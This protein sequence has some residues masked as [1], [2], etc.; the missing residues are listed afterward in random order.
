[1][2]PATTVTPTEAGGTVI[3]APHVLL[4]DLLVAD[5]WVHVRDG[6]VVGA[7]TGRP[8]AATTV[9]LPSGTLAPG[10]VDGQ[11]NGAFGHDLVAADGAGWRE[12]RTRL[13][14]TGVTAFVPTFITAPVDELA[15]ALQR[16]VALRADARRHGGARGLG[17]HLEGPFLAAGRHGAH[18]V[19][20]LT[21]PTDEAIDRLLAA[22][23]GGLAYVTLAPERPG[24]MAAIARFTA[25]GVRVA[26]G[27][28]DATDAQVTAA[29][30]AGATLVTH[31]YNAQRGLGHRD[32]GVVGAALTDPRLTVGLIVDLHH[33][34]PTAIRVA[35][36]AAGGRVMLVTDAVAAMGM[37]AGTYHLGAVELV[38]EDGRPPL[39]ADGTIAGSSLRLDRAVANAIAC[40]VAPATALLAASQVPAD[41]LG[42]PELGRIAPGAAADLVWLDDDWRAAATWIGGALVHGAEALGVPGAGA[43]DSGADRGTAHDPAGRTAR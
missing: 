4:G 35:F 16:T 10:L 8:P 18:Q 24:A 39:R 32:P 2:P 36:A 40:G 41:A 7:G 21:D 33:V 38:V 26:V 27:H 19:E 11:L 37:P 28:S 5:G 22:A 12:V 23:D 17:V 14:A 1:M 34:A 15:A 13:P 29:A 3:S 30:D 25:A 6:Q 42:H 31:L 43:D 9:T 20:Y